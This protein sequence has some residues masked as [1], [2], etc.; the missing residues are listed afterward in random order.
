MPRRPSARSIRLFLLVEALSF[1]AASLV[2]AGVLVGG[3]EHPRA[4][5]AESVIGLVLLAG[6]AVASLRPARARAAGLAAQ[7]FALL[8]TC[9]GLAMVAIGVGPQTVPDLVYHVAIL[10]VLAAGL[11]VAARAGSRRE[12]G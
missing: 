2:H 3:Y 5:T 11:V 7:G 4:R 1:L 8:G 10:L 6:L 9:V 12:P